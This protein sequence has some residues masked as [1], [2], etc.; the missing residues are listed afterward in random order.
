MI[1]DYHTHVLPG[2]DDGSKDAETS[3][4]MLIQLKEQGIERVIATPHFYAHREKSVEDFIEKRRNAYDSIK[5][6]LSLPV[7]LGAEV[8]IEH[9][10]SEIKDIDKLAIEGTR[11]I[12]LELP[13]R[14]YKE[15][16]SEEIYNISSEYGLKVVLAHIHRYT[17]YYSDEQMNEILKTDAVFQ[18]NNEAFDSHSSKSFVKNLLK[19]EVPI[20]FGSDAHN[21]TDRK[22]NWKILKKKRNMSIIEESAMIL[23]KYKV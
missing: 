21:L 16:M 10:I 11:L 9:G 1:T 13:Y 23:D 18:I 8:A 12:L 17:D 22:P 6:N 3:L 2:I 20:V 4:E 14:G 15:W 7:I 19:R 5:N